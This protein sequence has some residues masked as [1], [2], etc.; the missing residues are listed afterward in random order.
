MRS[1]TMKRQWHRARNSR[2]Y[3]QARPVPPS[4]RALGRGI[5]YSK[6]KREDYQRIERQWQRA[7]KRAAVRRFMREGMS[8]REA[9]I[10]YRVE[11]S[12]TSS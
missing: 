2:S 6:E 11:A 1:G 8:M 5:A 3:E 4:A 9:L 12:I 7:K 10:R